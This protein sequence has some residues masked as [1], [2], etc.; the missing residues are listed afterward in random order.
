MQNPALIQLSNNQT[1]RAY[2]HDGV[3]TT[4]ASLDELVI[5]RELGEYN[6]GARKWRNPFPFPLQ[7]VQ[8]NAIIRDTSNQVIVDEAL[9]VTFSIY[10]ENP[11]LTYAAGKMFKDSLIGLVV[12]QES[13]LRIDIQQLGANKW[14]QIPGVVMKRCALIGMGEWGF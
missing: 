5:I 9:T 2:T 8:A 3:L 1:A 6:T 14:L 10:R 12:P 13:F 11:D 4:A 7:I